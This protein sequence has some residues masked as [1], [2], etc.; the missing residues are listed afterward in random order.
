[1]GVFC[2][3]HLQARQ[4][5]ENVQ[6]RLQF[7]F[8]PVW[9]GGTC[10]HDGTLARRSCRGANAGKKGATEPPD[11]LRAIAHNVA[12]RFGKEDGDQEK[13]DARGDG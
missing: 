5:V 9:S 11:F 2:P 8:R 4:R 3:K 1:R 6:S 10:T 12:G 13:A 7:S